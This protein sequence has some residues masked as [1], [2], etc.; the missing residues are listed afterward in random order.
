MLKSRG[1][2]ENVI[3]AKFKKCLGM[4]VTNQNYIHH[5]IKSRLNS[6]SACYHSV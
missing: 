2:S 4:A 5:D 6:E 1:K 3:V